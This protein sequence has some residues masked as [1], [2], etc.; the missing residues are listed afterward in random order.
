MF[1]LYT[2]KL[3]MKKPDK[4]WNEEDLEWINFY[5]LIR[6]DVIQETV[7]KLQ[8]NRTEFEQRGVGTDLLVCGVW[9][10]FSETSKNFFLRPEGYIHKPNT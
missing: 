9:A 7:K 5:I 2:K 4:N 10:T 8:K 6:C 1:K 3:K